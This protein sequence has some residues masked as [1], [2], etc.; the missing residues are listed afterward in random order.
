MRYHNLLL[1]LIV[2]LL[3]TIPVITVASI[4]EVTLIYPTETQL[5]REPIVDTSFQMKEESKAGVIEIAP[6]TIDI[7]P[8][9]STGALLSREVN[10]KELPSQQVV[11][12]LVKQTNRGIIRE[13]IIQVYPESKVE[14]S[15]DAT[16]IHQSSSG[17][18]RHEFYYDYQNLTT[19]Q[20]WKYYYKVEKCGATT[21]KVVKADFNTRIVTVTDITLTQANG[22]TGIPQWSELP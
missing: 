4:D 18:M 9:L 15:D 20:P 1:I 17:D 6:I 2:I 22:I 10:A 3:Y 8:Y 7:Q 5:S 16:N 19:R 13:K 12:S 21:C 11:T 14:L